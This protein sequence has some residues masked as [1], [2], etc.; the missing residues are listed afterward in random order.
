MM[1]KVFRGILA[2]MLGSVAAFVTVGVLEVLGHMV[3]PP[4]PGLDMHDSTALKQ[5]PTGALVTV[6]LAWGIGTF[7][8]AWVAA[9]LAPAAKIAFG[10]GIG[11]LFLLAGVS[12]MIMIPHPIWMWVV[13]MAEPL[14]MAY[15]GAWLASDRR[16][17]AVSAV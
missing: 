7:I 9:R 2:V 15:F 10:L 11:V 6:L 13:G 16:G 5:L 17:P 1:N 12:T 8:G 4:P 14:P 3:F